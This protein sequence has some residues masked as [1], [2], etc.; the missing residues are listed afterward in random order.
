M[1]IGKKNNLEPGYVWVPYLLQQSRPVIINGS[2]NY[3]RKLKIKRLFNLGI[4]MYSKYS[5]NK[6]NSNYYKTIKIGK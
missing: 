5:T 2:K 4:S 1:L 3:S 6:I